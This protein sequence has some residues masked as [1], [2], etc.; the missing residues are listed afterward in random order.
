MRAF[1]TY[2]R[3]LLEYISIVWSPYHKCDTVDIENVQRTYTK[4]LPGFAEHSYSKPLLL[5]NLPS[6][7]LRGLHFDLIRRYKLIF[8]LVDISCTKV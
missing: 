4:R 3:P 6:L 1:L 5:L 8:G 7:E 2:V